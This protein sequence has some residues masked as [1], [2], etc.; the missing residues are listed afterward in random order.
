MSSPWNPDV[1]DQHAVVIGG[2]TRAAAHIAALLDAGARVTV[3]APELTASVADL[4]DRGLLQWSTAPA[5]SLVA[6]A[7]LVIRAETVTVPE[8]VVASVGDSVTP[9][10]T[11]IVTLVGAGPGDPDLLTVAAHRALAQADVVVADRLVPHAALRDLAPHARVI[12]VAKIP[13]GRTTPQGEINR[14]L[15][16]EALAGHTVVR[17]KGGDPFVFGRGS[18]E[19]LACADAGIA[20]RVLPGVTSAISGPGI[21]GIPVTHRG[22][23]QGFTVISGHVPPGH[24]DSTLDYAALA[25]SGT[26]LVVLMGVRTLSAICT[27]L[28]EAGLPR[29]TPAAV[30]ADATLPSQ[31]DVRGT[32]ATIAEVAEAHDLGAPAVAVIGDVADPAMLAKHPTD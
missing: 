27:A 3:V 29:H 13:R 19:L 9:T 28:I 21:A 23:T 24:P 1:T 26:T 16:T 7:D 2:G 20:T 4:V 25:R 12:D 32:V 5:E 14:I 11:G 30:I 10:A 17:L 31:R 18:E 6:V 8:P 22:L 15:V